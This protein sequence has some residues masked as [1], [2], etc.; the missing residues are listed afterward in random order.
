[1]LPVPRH[2]F[3]FER[4]T[5]LNTT[6]AVEAVAVLYPTYNLIANALGFTARDYRPYAEAVVD[7]TLAADMGYLIIDPVDDH[8]VG[9]HFSLDLLD[10]LAAVEAMRRSADDRIRAWAGLLG[11][12]FD[13]R[14]QVYAV[15]SERGEV[16]YANI[17]ALHE[18]ARGC[19]L[20][21]ELTLRTGLEFAIG[22]GY[23]RG[24]GIATHPQSRSMVEAS[25]PE[26]SLELPYAELEDPRLQRLDGSARGV[27]Y[28]IHDRQPTGFGLF[29]ADVSRSG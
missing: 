21:P 6:R 17:M 24:F 23:A 14:A 19:G 2:R 7:A 29:K 5:A 4:L 11:R 18:R 12:I 27:Q 25:S 26:W 15:P 13:A 8:V 16:Y 1:M 22:R 3:S 20:M 10:E 28:R 9:F